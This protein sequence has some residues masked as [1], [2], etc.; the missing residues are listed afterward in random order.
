[1]P[2]PVGSRKPITALAAMAASMALPPSLRMSSATCV[3][4][5]WLVAAIPFMAME[6]ERA[7]KAGPS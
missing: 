2:L 3:A 6:G 5:G 4:M 7:A 1:M